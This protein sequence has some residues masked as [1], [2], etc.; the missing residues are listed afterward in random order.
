MLNVLER[1]RMAG[2]LGPGPV[3]DHIGHSEQFLAALLAGRGSVTSESVSDEPVERELNTGSARLIDLGSGGGV[4]ALPLLVVD[5]DLSAVLVDSS[6][7][8]C[9]FLVWAITELGLGDRVQVWCG[10]AEEIAHQERA[11]GQFDFA[12]ARGFGPPATTVECSAPLLH[13]QGILAISEP[14]RG[15]SWPRIELAEV[16]LAKLELDSQ[17]RSIAVFARTGPVDGKFPRPSKDQQRT[18]LF[19]L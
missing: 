12:T 9:S 13:E 15:R 16:G 3:A 17:H 2:F 19:V 11:R 7:K 10:R 1:S 4:P 6:Q 5:Q 18:P 14:P 8:R